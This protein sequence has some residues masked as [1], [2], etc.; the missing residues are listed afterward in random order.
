MS[1]GSA[2]SQFCIAVGHPTKFGPGWSSN[3]KRGCVSCQVVFSP[4]KPD[5]K[6]V[7]AYLKA[8]PSLVRYMTANLCWEYGPDAVTVAAIRVEAM[9]RKGLCPCD[10]QKLR[11]VPV[12][13]ASYE[14]P[15]APRVKASR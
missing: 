15:E 5:R 6:A 1:S 4:G 7:D 9:V 10:S 13:H 2:C 11:L 14:F 3:G 8:N 12:N